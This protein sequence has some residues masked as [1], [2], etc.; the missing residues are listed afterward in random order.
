MGKDGAMMRT[1]K[2]ILSVV[3]IFIFSWG[4]AHSEPEEIEGEK[5]TF[6]TTSDEME[7]VDTSTQKSTEDDTVSDSGSEFDK[8]TA[9]TI[10]DTN[11][12]VDTGQDK[13]T[14]CV[15]D[16]SDG[17]CAELDCDDAD[18]NVRPGAVE[19]PENGKDD[20]CD[21]IVDENTFQAAGLPADVADLFSVV[22]DGG[23]QPAIVYPAENVLLPPNVNGIVFQWEPG[24]GNNVWRVNF[25]GDGFDAVAYVN[26]ARFMPDG[27][28]WQ[29]LAYGNLNKSMRV[30]VQGTSLGAPTSK[31]TSAP[32]NIA[33]AEESVRGGLY[34][35]AASSTTGADYGIMRYDFGN[36]T[37]AQAES[38]YTAS[39]AGRCVACHALSHDGTRMALNYDGGGG[40]A[41]IIDI[42]TRTTTVP[43]GSQYYANFH[44]FS[45]DDEYLLSVSNGKFTLRDGY[46]GVAIETLDLERVT[47]PDWSSNGTHV[48]YTRS[49]RTD[50]G[51]ADWS[52]YGGQI[53]VIDFDGPGNWSLPRVIVPAEPNIN[54]YY[55][56]I[57]PDGGWVVFNRSYAAVS[58]R[59]DATWDSYSDDSAELWAVSIDGGT[60]IRLDAVNKAA[61]LR[62]SWAKW[63]P[64]EQKLG[65][66]TI[67][68][69]TTS[70]IRSYPPELPAGNLPQI[71]MAAFHVT[72]AEEGLDPSRPGFWLPFQDK[73]TNNHIPQWTTQVIEVY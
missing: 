7:G 21:G 66:D 6:D 62:N 28:F 37:Q 22:E 63:V 64:F 30:T 26:E 36:P 72:K 10:A 16:D 1:R 67:F 45:P 31:G 33:F 2:K 69:L 34:Y 70:S 23:R 39:Q 49:M 56:A 27:A 65:D 20:N 42:S 59:C 4:C 57:S 25:D 44:T 46:S 18:S 14:F 68:W 19:I 73:T 60:L 51:F 29:N 13:D 9:G 12:T 17:W 52:M 24:A 48:V 55:P 50:C 47:Y 40:I 11:G 43:G 38:I 53:E 5:G 54:N 8:S 61:G 58:G 41:D 15:D 32:L 35:W 71:W 3:V